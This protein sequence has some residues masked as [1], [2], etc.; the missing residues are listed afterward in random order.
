MCMSVEVPTPECDKMVAI[1]DKSQIIGEFIDWLTSEKGYTIAELDQ[2][3]EEGYQNYY[4][5]SY[6][7]EKLLAEFFEI[8]LN[9]VEAERRAIL[10]AIRS[11]K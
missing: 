7:M 8:D 11:K 2:E 3:A 1:R 10:E 9:K 6:S 4:P 5:V